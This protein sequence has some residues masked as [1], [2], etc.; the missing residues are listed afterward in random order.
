[1]FIAREVVA[2]GVVTIEAAGGGDPQRPGMVKIQP[3]RFVMA[4]TSGVVGMMLI[5]RK[6]PG[7]VYSID[8]WFPPT[9]SPPDL[10]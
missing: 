1:M 9:S 3:T 10:Q 7:R 5:M 4:E 6:P 2:R 8:R